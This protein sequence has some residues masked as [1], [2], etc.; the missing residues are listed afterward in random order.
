RTGLAGVGPAGEGH[1][2]PII[3]GELGL[4]CHAQ[5]EVGLWEA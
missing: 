4:G 1:F 5:Y 3:G 2:R